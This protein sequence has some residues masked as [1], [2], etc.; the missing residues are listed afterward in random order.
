MNQAQLKELCIG[1]QSYAARMRKHFHL[2]PELSGREFETVGAIA[3]ELDAIGVPYEVIP[4]GGIL[5]WIETG[6]DD[7]PCVLLRADCDAL[8]VQEAECNGAGKREYISTRPGIA[9]MCGHDAHTAMLLAAARV[10]K[11]SDLSHLKGKI[12]LLFER[13]EEGGLNYYYVLRHI[14]SRNIQIDSCFALHVDPTL[15]TGSLWV[16][17]GP[18]HAGNVN[19]EI[20]LEGKGGHGS[21]PDRGN[22]PLDCF[23]AIMNDLNSFR[24]K[25]VSPQ[26]ILTINVGSVHSGAKRNIIPETLEFKGTCRFYQTETGRRFKETLK[27]ILELNGELY[28]C[29]VH[30]QVFNGPSLSQLNHPGASALAREAITELL[31]EITLVREKELEMSSET[32]GVLCAYYP[33]TMALLG[34]GNPEKGTC[35]PLHNPNFDLDPD[36]LYLGIAAHVAYALK[37]LETQPTFSH[38]PFP[39][40]IDEMMRFTDRK[41]PRPL[42]CEHQKG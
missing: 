36:A 5:G 30:Y 13:G 27:K 3:A 19:F 1:Q 23:V 22:N 37:Y 31:P 35:A 18:C 33:G 4:D 8:P 38:Q 17:A 26:D 42:D 24:M 10:L 16:E 25:H 34:T 21:R 9:H 15:P 40:D 28:D 12:C 32:Y 2:H 11:S 7:G 29:K 6:S 39:G 41:A 20:T 14:Q